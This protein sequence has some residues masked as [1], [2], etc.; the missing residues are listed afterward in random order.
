MSIMKD[1]EEEDQKYINKILNARPE[2]TKLEIYSVSWE[3]SDGKRL[4]SEMAK[5]KFLG[6][7]SYSLTKKKQVLK[8]L[9]A[10]VCVENF[11][12][13]Y[14]INRQIFY[15]VPFK[16]WKDA[17]Y[18]CFPRRPLEIGLFYYMPTLFYRR[19]SGWDESRKRALT[20][21]CPTYYW[22]KKI[23]LNYL[24]T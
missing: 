3:E 22:K 20:P 15:Q 19:L 17:P 16:Q 8:A 2:L 6:L 13:Q 23:L 4:S 10:S 14:P 18:S 7:K 9:G 21:T 12:I 11:R 5:R 24:L 1:L